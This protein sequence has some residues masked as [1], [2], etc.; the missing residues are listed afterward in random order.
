M[1]LARK[2]RVAEANDSMTTT[3]NQNETEQASCAPADGSAVDARIAAKLS[4]R[5]TVHE[6]L[7]SIGVPREERGKPLCLL[8]RLRITCDRYARMQDALSEMESYHSCTSA[9]YDLIATALAPHEIEVS[10]H[11]GDATDMPPQSAP[12]ELPQREQP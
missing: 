9:Q 1:Q 2:R 12:H 10:D 4:E 6:W 8:R 11:S 7:N 5:K 3:T